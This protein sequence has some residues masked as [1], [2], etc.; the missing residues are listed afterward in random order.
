MDSANRL[1]LVRKLAHD[2]NGP[3]GNVTAFL[4]LAQQQIADAISSDEVDKATVEMG[5]SMLS[6]AMP[7]IVQLQRNIRMWSASHQ[8]VSQEYGVQLS[9]ITVKNQ[10]DHSFK[11]LEVF[12]H[13]K[14]I[15]YKVVGDLDC[16]ILMDAE[17]Y[18]LIIFHLFDLAITVGDQNQE[19]VFDLHSDERK[20]LKI[21]LKLDGDYPQLKELLLSKV[22]ELAALPSSFDAGVIKSL[23]YGNIFVPLAVHAMGGAISV[24]LEGHMLDIAFNFESD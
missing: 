2:I 17:L 21:G 18:G 6:M 22:A 3:L 23:A 20:G 24:Q 1:K 19:I 14:E 5:L 10:I 4:D 16:S 8:I 7:T 15:T 9:P 13:K 12:L 11:E